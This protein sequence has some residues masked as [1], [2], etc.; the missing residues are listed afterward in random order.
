MVRN[1]EFACALLDRLLEINEL[2][3]ERYLG[4]IGEFVD[5]LQLADDLGQQQ[6]PLMP[7]AQYRKI[8]RPRQKELFRFVKERTD[9]YFFYHTCGSVIQYVPDLIQL[10]VDILNPVRTR[11]WSLKN[12]VHPE[13][14]QWVD[15][16]EQPFFRYLV[17]LG[18]RVSS[19]GL[20]LEN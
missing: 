9:A 3:L 12:V 8:I 16:L 5:V 19:P 17:F 1:P 6:G 13:A 2:Y 10:G 4:E 18:R 7:L 14:L 20:P 15:V 11:L